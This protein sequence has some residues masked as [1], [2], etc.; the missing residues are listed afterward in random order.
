MESTL[1]KIIENLEHYN[2][3]FTKNEFYP[4]QKA[5][6]TPHFIVLGV[7]VP[8]KTICLYIGR[9]HQY[10]GCYVEEKMPPAFLRL[11]DKFL[12]YVRRYLVGAKIGKIEFKR[13]SGKEIFSFKYKTDHDQNEFSFGYTDREFFFF[14]REKDLVHCSWD[15]LI[16]DHLD[17]RPPGSDFLK[18]KVFN[19]IGKYIQSEDLKS[20][21][22]IEQK[23]K[24]KFLVKKID[25]I[26]KDLEVVKEWR[27][28]EEKLLNEELDLEVE[29]LKYKSHTFNFIGIKNHWEK[30]DLI[31]KKIKKLKKGESLLK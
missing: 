30:R 25:N 27:V 31:F 8:G 10:M 18:H 28:I 14:R 11:Q 19:E 7:R 21:G 26:K 20:S 5:Y 3:Y 2:K 24:E 22:S 1:N 29:K 15:N 13:E 16:C 12:D 17:V 23:K 9:G 6:T 4:V